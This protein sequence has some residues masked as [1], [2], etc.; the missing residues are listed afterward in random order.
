MAEQILRM[1][2][3]RRLFSHGQGG[4]DWGIAQARS[5]PDCVDVSS[6]LPACMLNILRFRS[7]SLGSL[8]RCSV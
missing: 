5:R 3:A 7:R 4:R 1:S 8:E 6:G 2:R